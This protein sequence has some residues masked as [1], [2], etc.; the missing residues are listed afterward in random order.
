MLP[1]TNMRNLK[2]VCAIL[3][4]VAFFNH[5]YGYY[6]VLRWTIMIASLYLS[7]QYFEKKEE[8]YGW[9]FL[10]VGILFNPLLPFFFEKSTWQILNL[11]AA[12]IYIISLKQKI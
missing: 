7:F 3:L 1:I 8:K 10:A 5:P 11:I 2:I 12:G 4:T 9:T 6:Q